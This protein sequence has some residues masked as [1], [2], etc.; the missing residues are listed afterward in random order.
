MD[1]RGNALTDGALEI[2]KSA[3]EP[4]VEEAK[5]AECK[6]DMRNLCAPEGKY[7]ELMWSFSGVL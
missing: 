7:K 6:C 2:L 3:L 5:W 1:L 4:N